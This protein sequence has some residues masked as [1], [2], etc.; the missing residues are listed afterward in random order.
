MARPVGAGGHREGI[1]M[2]RL[3]VEPNAAETASSYRIALAGDALADAARLAAINGLLAESAARRGDERETFDRF[4]AI[5][6]AL[7]AAR[8]LVRIARR[9]AT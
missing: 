2:S 5:A 1:R 7:D 4:R 3:A 6:H 9:G 8:E